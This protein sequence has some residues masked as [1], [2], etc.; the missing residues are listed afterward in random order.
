MLLCL[1]LV[2]PRVEKVRPKT[3]LE[4]VIVTSVKDYLPFPK[5]LLYPLVQRKNK[6]PLPDIEYNE[7]TL[8]LPR[9][10]ANGSNEEPSIAIDPKKR[11]SRCCNILGE[12]PD[13]LKGSC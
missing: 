8:S 3:K 4:Y 5:N 13:R 2:F 9:L 10:L 12:R 11:I 1:D 6:M 7:H